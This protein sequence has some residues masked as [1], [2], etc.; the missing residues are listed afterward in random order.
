MSRAGLDFDDTCRLQLDGI[1]D[2]T[3]TVTQFI[4]QD[5]S[6]IEDPPGQFDIDPVDV[7]T[8]IQWCL[9]SDIHH[10]GR[11][12]G[13]FGYNAEYLGDGRIEYRLVSQSVRNGRL[14]A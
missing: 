9:P 14:L 4:D 2:S 3:L 1:A 10:D 8:D 7:Q 12:T 13:D 11:I 5:Y 6:D